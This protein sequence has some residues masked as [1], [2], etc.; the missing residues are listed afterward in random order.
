MA[1]GTVTW[2]DPRT[3][4]GTIT[5][6]DGSAALSIHYAQIDGG[7]RQSLRVNDRVTYT[8]ATGPAGP[9]ATR[10]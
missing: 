10:V 7:G 1:H 9:I 5:P 8:P 4:V 6:D 2:F 3:G